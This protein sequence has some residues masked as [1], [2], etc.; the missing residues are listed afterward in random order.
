MFSNRGWRWNK[1]W[2]NTRWTHTNSL[3]RGVTSNTWYLNS[4]H[5]L[6]YG[7]YQSWCSMVIPLW[8]IQAVETW[9]DCHHSGIPSMSLQTKCIT[10]YLIPELFVHWQIPRGEMEHLENKQNFT[11]KGTMFTIKACNTL[12]HYRCLIFSEF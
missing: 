7:P 10:R 9:I 5:D 6:P 3:L 8:E 1:S 12:K 11:T 4:I 2:A